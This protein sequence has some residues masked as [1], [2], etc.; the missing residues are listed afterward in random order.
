[1][2]RWDFWL[3]TKNYDDAPQKNPDHGSDG[4]EA[5]V[6]DS[7]TSPWVGESVEA[8][9]EFL[10]KAPASVDVER[11]FFAVLDD[12]TEKDGS[13]V[14]CRVG[15]MEGQGDKVECIRVLAKNS[16]L[17][18][19]GMEYGTWEEDLDALQMVGRRGKDII[20]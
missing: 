17:Y 9:A 19:A 16:A 13:V 4:T 12:R 1:M 8:A 20:N 7:F 5:P 10:S 18:L 15:D 2:E 11:R 3:A 14:M 6:D